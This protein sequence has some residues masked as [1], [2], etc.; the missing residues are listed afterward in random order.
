VGPSIAYYIWRVANIAIGSTTLR[1]Q[2]SRGVNRAAREFL[3]DVPFSALVHG[4]GDR[5]LKELDRQT[6]LLKKRLPRKARHWG[7]ARKALNV[8]LGEVYYHRV[9]CDHF[10][11]EKVAEFLEVPL[12]E[13]VSRFL[14]DKAQGSGKTLPRWPRIKRLSPQESKQ[15]QE[16]A[17]EYARSRGKGWIRL[18]VDLEAWRTQGRNGRG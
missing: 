13:D 15:Y 1:N 9:L 10:G 17:R 2:G 7:T 8:F 14:R 12:D 3:A 5:F 18:H 11:M 16:F 4:N 6:V